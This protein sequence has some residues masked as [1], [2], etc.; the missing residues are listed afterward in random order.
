MNE[1]MNE[2][3]FLICTRCGSRIRR[4]Q[5]NCLKCG[6]LNFEN[7]DND[8][9]KK[10]E[11]KYNKGINSNAV[12]K[13]L[14]I[15][16]NKRPNE[17]IADNTGNIFV[18]GIINLF[19][20]IVFGFMVMSSFSSEFNREFILLLIGLEIFYLELYSFQLLLMKANKP[21]WYGHIFFG[22]LFLFTFLIYIFKIKLFLVLLI[23]L[24]FTIFYNIGH[25]FGKNPWICIILAPVM[26]PIIAFSNTVSY[27]GVSYIIVGKRNNTFELLN[28]YNRIILFFN[29]SL[30]II[31]FILLFF[32]IIL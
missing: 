24:L 10:Y 18:F 9:M 7:P 29:I 8:Y 21:W 6:Q 19:V 2:S 31:G 15:Y 20:F 27:N 23:I 25:E 26:L 17:V 11:K 5:R 13:K 14:S 1:N 32:L 3:K 28:K 30:I 22:I 4:E 16:N 12:V